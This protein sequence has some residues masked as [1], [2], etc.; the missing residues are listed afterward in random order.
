MAE[1]LNHINEEAREPEEIGEIKISEEVV[2]VVAGL[3]VGEVNG[4]SVANS[5]TDSVVEKFVRKNYGKGIRIEMTEKEVSVDVHVVVEYGI[6]IPEVA[7]ELQEAVKKNV[8]TMTNLTVTGVNV[9]VEGIVVEREPKTEAKEGKRTAKEEKKEEKRAKK[10][11]A[12]AAQTEES[13]SEEAEPKAEE[14]QEEE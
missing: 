5:L 2:L 12:K 11:A 6:K 8:E 9:F 7:W 13:S 14:K 4:V 1:E 10:E 3:A